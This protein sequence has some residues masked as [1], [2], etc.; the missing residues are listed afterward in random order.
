MGRIKRALSELADAAT[1]RTAFLWAEGSK[2]AVFSSFLRFLALY[3]EGVF[4]L[5]S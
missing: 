2:N 4:L 1:Y 5:K 3:T